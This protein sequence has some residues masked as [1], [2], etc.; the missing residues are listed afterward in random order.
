M[1]KRTRMR[2]KLREKVKVMRRWMA[3]KMASLLLRILLSMVKSKRVRISLPTVLKM[4][5][6]IDM[7]AA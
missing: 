1:T 6:C 4:S 3:W 5:W 2:R 7:L